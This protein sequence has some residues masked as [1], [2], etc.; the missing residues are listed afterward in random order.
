MLSVIG[1]IRFAMGIPQNIVEANEVYQVEELP[2]SLD[3]LRT[4]QRSLLS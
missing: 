1:L 3:P 2:K 4:I